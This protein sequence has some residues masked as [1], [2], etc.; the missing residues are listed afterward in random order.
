MEITME[1]SWRNRLENEFSQPYF[2]SLMQFVESENDKFPGGIFPKQDQIFRAFEACPFDKVKVVILGQDPYPT[3]GHANGLCFSVEP[4]VRPLPKS[5]KNVYK[6]LESDLGVLPRENGDLNAWAEQGVLMLNSIL[7]VREGEAGGHKK[8]GWETFTDAVISKLNEEKQGVVY[9]L[10]GNG[11][12]EKA[13]NVNGE[14]NLILSASHPSPLGA[15][16]SFWGCKHF[17]K[18][19]EY[20]RSKGK[21]AI[22]W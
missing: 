1:S 5:L 11:A 9:I 10:W 22:D 19:N 21:D 13:K 15:Y 2:Q 7:T 3:K 17:S 18:S 8:K 14:A 20:L 12:I 16:R 6:E 4:D